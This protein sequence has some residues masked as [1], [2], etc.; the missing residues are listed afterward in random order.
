MNS[1]SFDL[2]ESSASAEPENVP[3]WKR[4]LAFTMDMILLVV[5]L[6]L[7]VQFL[8]NAYSDHVKQEFNQLIIDA[9]L[10]SQEEQSDLQR[11]TE[12]L[13]KS[14]L[15]EETYEMLMAMIF[16]ACLL[17]STYFFIGELFFRGQT[18]GKATLRLRTA[19]VRPDLPLTPLR[20]FARAVLKGISALSLMSPFFIPGLIN[21]LF[22]FFN[23]K[24]RCLH[25]LAGS[26]ITISS[27]EIPTV[28]NES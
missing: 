20:L 9:S 8:P 24:K 14:Q 2:R 1:N 15:S 19:S 26:S 27:Q 6:Q 12:F 28:K 7:L 23:R 10:L 25:D 22:C 18:L 21:F 11:T 3:T 4:I 13:E 16:F 17:P 5:L